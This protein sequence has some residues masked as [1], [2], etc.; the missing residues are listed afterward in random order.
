MTQTEINQVVDAMELRPEYKNILRKCL[1]GDID[2]IKEAIEELNQANS[3]ISTKVNEL[4]DKVNNIQ[5]DAFAVVD[6]LPTENIENK[7][8]C[9]KDTTGGGTNNK[10]IEYI[11]IES[12]KSWEKVGEFKADPDLSGYAKLNGAVFKGIVEFQNQVK[13]PA[14]TTVDGKTIGTAEDFVFTL[15]DGAT[16]TKSIRVISTTSSTT[17]S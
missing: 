12:T 2:S 4:T 9:I 16:V 11:Y 7:I 14:N 1:S 17:N 8:Y 6:K 5:T 10:Y 15:E 13:L 3:D